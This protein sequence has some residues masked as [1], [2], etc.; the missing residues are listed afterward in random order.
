M[1]TT[2]GLRWYALYLRSRHERIVDLRLREKGV[3]TL[4]PLIE[5]VRQYSDRKKRVLAPLFR[6][7]LFFRM[8]I[9]SRLHVVQTEGVVRI[10]GIGMRPSPI[11]ENQVEWIRIAMRCPSK[12]HRER[13]LA[14]GES[15]R[16]AA[17]PF[18]GI[19]GSVLHQKDSLRVV[20]SVDCIG[21]SVSV[22]TQ[23]E[24]LARL[25]A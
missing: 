4:L 17:G 3:E 12:I 7:Y 20:V 25:S 8:D 16:I 21:Q 22:E 23:P 24:D 13:Y 11:P 9:G 5:E 19:Q 18:A 6:G 10:V 1:D 2:G 15:V 14:A